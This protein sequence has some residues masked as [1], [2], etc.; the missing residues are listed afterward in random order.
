[1]IQAEPQHSFLSSK[2]TIQRPVVASISVYGKWLPNQHSLTAQ[3]LSLTRSGIVGHDST[4]L[5]VGHVESVLGGAEGQ[6]VRDK[7]TSIVDG[8]LPRL[9]ELAT[10]TELENTAIAVAVW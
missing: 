6:L 2:H 5:A 4:V 3:H 9:K 1:M 10:R 8:I 7:E